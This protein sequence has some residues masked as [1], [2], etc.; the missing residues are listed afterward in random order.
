MRGVRKSWRAG[1]HVQSLLCPPKKWGSAF[2][3]TSPL[4]TGIAG[5]TGISC[6]PAPTFFKREEPAAAIILVNHAPRAGAD[7]RLIRAMN[8]EA[9]GAPFEG[10]HRDE[11]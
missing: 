7:Q 10:E 3:A 1:P 6:G 4:L 2:G 8:L 5:Q 9:G 11:P